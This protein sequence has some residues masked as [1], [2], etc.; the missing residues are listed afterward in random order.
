LLNDK[1]DTLTRFLAERNHMIVNK[2]V[3]FNLGALGG[4]L[5]GKDVVVLV[6]VAQYAVNAEWCLTSIAESLYLTFVVLITVP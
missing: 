6:L 3:N 5:E 1:I 2:L 4:V